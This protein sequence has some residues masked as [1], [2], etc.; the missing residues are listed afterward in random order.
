MKILIT[1]IS[2]FAGSYLA[3]RLIN[4][5]DNDVFG[6][7]RWRSSRENIAHLLSE[8]NLIEAD[9]RDQSSLTEAINTIKPDRIY[10]LAAQSFVP[11]SWN[12]PSECISTNVLGTLNLLEAVKNV[13]ISPRILVACSSEE[14]G[15]VDESNL[16]VR[17]DCPLQPLSPYAVSKV[18]QDML[19]YQYYRSYDMHIVR[20]RA[21]NH[22]G[23]R[24]PEFFVCSSFA[25]QIAMAE[26]DLKPPVIQVGNLDA[27][28]DFSDVRDI[29]VAYD[30]ALE[31]CSQ[32]EVYNI[33]SGKGYRIGDLLNMMVA[34]SSK[35]LEIHSDE[36]RLRPSDVPVLIGDSEAFREIAAWKPEISIEQTL[37]DILD[38]WRERITP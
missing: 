8:L 27:V 35:K 13:G 17:E 6:L 30:R 9:V 10:H 20:T 19:A 25:Y 21:F 1:G 22:T 33:C 26:A 16:P 23:P 14:Y 34:M 3:E 15:D 36:K 24:R 32:G 29:A 31:Y 28:R 38:Y 12:A 18:G 37:K 11:F 4:T 7:I 2:G 5:S